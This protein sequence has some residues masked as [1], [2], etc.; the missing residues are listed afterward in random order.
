MQYLNPTPVGLLSYQLLQGGRGYFDPIFLQRK[1]WGTK[2]PQEN[3]LKIG[4]EAKKCHFCVLLAWTVTVAILHPKFEKV[5]KTT[6]NVPKTLDNHQE[7]LVLGLGYQFL[8]FQHQ[9]R[10]QNNFQ[11]SEFVT[12]V[13][14]HFKPHKCYD[15]HPHRFI[16]KVNFFGRGV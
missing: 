9:K 14:R 3:F 16:G 12:A 6:Q 15:R 5:I 11:D 4:F 8:S 10:P 2:I 1:G 7:Q 13:F